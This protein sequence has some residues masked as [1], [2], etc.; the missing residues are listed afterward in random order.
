M[1][2]L[3]A[4]MATDNDADCIEWP[5]GHNGR[6]YGLITTGGKSVYV[7]RFVCEKAYGAPFEGAHAAHD[8][9]NH[10]CVNPHHLRWSTVKDNHADKVRH[11]TD[12]RGEK[13][14]RARVTADQVREIRKRLADGMTQK[15]VAE[16]FDI[17]PESVGS[18]HRGDS[19]VWLT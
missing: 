4:A 6:G 1:A 19:W 9:G 18:I 13:H 15:A 8:C 17:H 10:R 14:Y 16:A 7:H 12:N 2:F 3:D 11:G 5:F